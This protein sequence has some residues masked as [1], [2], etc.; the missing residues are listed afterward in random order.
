MK[1][2]ISGNN[3][4]I[5]F[6][7]LLVYSFILVQF[8]VPVQAELDTGYDSRFSTMTFAVDNNNIYF[9][10][11]QQGVIYIYSQRGDFRR[12]YRLNKLGDRMSFMSAGTTKK[13]LEEIGDTEE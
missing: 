6:I 11:T 13:M 12:A 10:D 2:I 5:A 8:I 4:L 3:I 9:Y 7:V 1:S